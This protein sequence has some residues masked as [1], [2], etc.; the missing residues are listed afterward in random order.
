MNEFVIDPIVIENLQTRIKDGAISYNDLMRVCSVP[1][2]LMY[3]PETKMEFLGIELD[4]EEKQ[5]A[6]KKHG[7]G[8]YFC[9]NTERVAGLILNHH[10]VLHVNKNG[11]NVV[12][13]SIAIKMLCH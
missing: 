4:G 7:Y 6:I 3:S 8:P 11:Y 1:V 12:P 13:L 9:W 5:D 10:G 2:D